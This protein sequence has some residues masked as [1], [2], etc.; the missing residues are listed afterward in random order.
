MCCI[1][2]VVV[3]LN[4]IYQVVRLHLPSIAQQVAANAER[5]LSSAITKSLWLLNP[6]ALHVC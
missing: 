3:V 5:P 1:Y 6:H 2:F 4:V